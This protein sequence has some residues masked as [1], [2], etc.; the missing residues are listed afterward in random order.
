MSFSSN[1]LSELFQLELIGVGLSYGHAECWLSLLD[2]REAWFEAVPWIGHVE[3][4]FGADHLEVAPVREVDA[5]IEVRQSPRTELHGGGEGD[6][7]PCGSEHLV[8]R[9][10]SGFTCEQASR[11]DAVDTDVEQRPAVQ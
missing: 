5:A 6:I 4:A 11:T 1:G 2:H 10:G 8:R 3:G 7:D 9:H